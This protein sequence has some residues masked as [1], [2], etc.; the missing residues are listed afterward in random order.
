[1]IDTHVNLHH[2]LYHD[3]LVEVLARAKAGNI[4]GMLSICDKI[5]NFQAIIDIV[6]PLDNFWASVGAHPHEAKD[7]LG[8]TTEELIQFSKNQNVIGIGETGLDFHYG[9][10]P[11]EVQIRVFET[12]IHSSQGTQL[13]LIVHTREADMKMGEILVSEHQNSNFPLL[14]HCY[15]SG[16]DLLKKALDLGAFVSISG[17]ATFKNAEDVR[18]NIKYIPKDRLL[19]ETDCPYLAPIPKRGQRNEPLF[20]NH[21][22][23][24]LAEFLG[25]DLGDLTSELDNNFF[26][27]FTR[28]KNSVAK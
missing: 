23:E 10:S 21:L 5:D 18:S 15:T 4:H 17:I 9:L 3:D 2:H 19:V 6:S 8:L 25:R 26:S 1:M 14:M 7:H 27:L 16:K 28:A 12:H 20:L 22:V 13:P 11:E 24:Y